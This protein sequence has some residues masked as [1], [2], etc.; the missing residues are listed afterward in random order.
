[1]L[2]IM[3]TTSIALLLVCA[4][5]ATYE[6]ISFRRDMV[7]DLNIM[8]EV[9]G[10]NCAASIDFND[11]KSATETL[12][13]LKDQPHIMGAFIYTKAG[14]VFASYNRPNDVV[15]LSPPTYQ[16][17]GYQFAGNRL[18]LFNPINYKGD[19]VGVVYIVSD[20]QGL[21]A[22]LK[23]YAGIVLG[24]FGVTLIVA[25]LLSVRLQELISEPI[26]HL[27]KTARAVARDK[28][29]SLRAVK[30]SNDEIGVLIEGFNEMLTQIQQR[31]AALQQA[32][33]DLEKRVAERTAELAGSVSLL[34]ATLESTAD[35]ILVV[36]SEGRVTHFNEKFASMWQIPREI[37]ATRDDRQMMDFALG[38]VKEP[39]Q[40]AAGVK[41]LYAHPEKES[42][43]LLEFKD[44]RVF[45]R[46]S[47]PQFI[48]Q[49]CVG[50]VWNFR[51]ITERKK[52]EAKLNKAN[53]QLLTTSR[54]AGMAEVATSVLHNVGNV[55]NSVNISSSMIS[56]KIRGS[57]VS[58]LAKAVTLMQLH[59]ADL[60][61][62][63]GQDP[64][65]RQLP[66]YL[67]KLATHL[68]D[69]Q[70][71]ILEELTLLCGNIEH[72][73]E[74]VTMQQSYAKVTGAVE[75][76]AVTDL[77][78]D[79]L[80]MNAGALDRHQ[81]RLIR[82]Y[83]PVPPLQMEKHKVLQ[84]LI[85]LIRNAKYAVDDNP[86]EDKRLTLRVAMDGDERV[87]I[88][89]IDNGMGI[90]AENLTRIFN[91]GFTT[92]KD[93]HGFGLHSGAL[94]AKELGGALSVHSEGP[95]KGAA[96]TLELP[97]NRNNDHEK[98]RT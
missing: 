45:E 6:V 38:Q 67:E 32:Q 79:A 47:K 21:N 28:N 54:L 58:S 1:M 16:T 24:V 40:F 63:L 73:K 34:H 71:D 97:A 11:A 49:I 65:G 31:D 13:G 61:A 35:G 10:D 91:H 17:S 29:Y 76:L 62:F 20:M 14:K 94:S 19:T 15:A 95:G 90:P 60:P 3:L 53:D 72:I 59:A 89:V 66:A 86:N 52:A 9:I 2:I 12:A 69:E 44:G 80:R 68:A 85:N 84:I 42:F 81:V 46:Q 64:K 96:F 48:E 27:V 5:F 70:K 7:R 57:K 23:E 22:R 30:Q 75:T 93:G 18:M 33:S 50:R 55:L 74:I 25:Y 4:A 56:E 26:L 77:V 78:E 98:S 39:E 88:S 87:K 83:S 82:E 41:E 92:R 37:A 36:D 8:A 43:D 51:D